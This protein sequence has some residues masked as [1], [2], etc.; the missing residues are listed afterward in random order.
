MAQNA[1][2]FYSNPEAMLRAMGVGAPEGLP[3]PEFGNPQDI[4]KQRD[5][6][7]ASIFKK[8]RLLYKILERHEATIQ[9][10]W[11]K[12]TKEQKRK[13]VLAAW[14]GAMPTAHRPDFEAFKKMKDVGGRSGT[15]YRADF[16]WPYINQE[17]LTK[18]K[19]LLLFMNARGRHPPSDFAAA[20]YEAMHIGVVTQSIMPVFLNEHV[21]LFNGKKAEADYA[22]LLSWDDHPDAFQWLHTRKHMQ[23]GEGLLILEAQEK[24]M[25]FLVKCAKSILHDVA[26]ESILDFSPQPAPPSISD[27][28]NGFA[29]LALI[30]A[31][32]AYRTPAHLSWD[33][34]VSLLNAKRAAAEDHLW[35]LRDDPSYFSYTMRDARE[36]RQEILADTR[37]QAHPVLRYGREDILWARIIGSEVTSAQIVFEAWAELHRQSVE[38]RAL[39]K[40]HS[41]KIKSEDDLPTEYL[42]AILRFRH[43]LNETTKGPIE[44]LKVSF[45]SSPPWRGYFVRQP[46]DDLKQAWIKI[47]SKPEVST[48]YPENFILYFFRILWSDPQSVHL[49]KMTNVV[50]ELQHTI[51]SDPKAKDLVSSTCAAHIGDLSILGE[52]IR[53]IELYQPW[54]NMFEDQMVDMQSDIDADYQKRTLPWARLLNAT[55]G[56]EDVLAR[57]GTPTPERF[58]YPVEKRRTKETTE[59]MRFAEQNLDAFW[60]KVDELVHRNAGDLRGTATRQLMLQPRLL[61]RT[62][63]WT[64]PKTNQN[65]KSTST[66]AGSS[67]QQ[68]DALCKPLSEIYFDLEYRTEAKGKNDS[69]KDTQPRS[70]P[71]TRGTPAPNAIPIDGKNNNDLREDNPL[72]PQPIFAVDNRALKV[73]KTVFYTPSSGSTPGEVP[74]ADFVHA[75]VATGFK[76]EK[77]YGSVWQFSPTK[78]DIERSIQFHEPH[79]SG[80]IPYWIARR[81]GRRLN[82]AYGWFGG[83]FKLAEK[84]D[85]A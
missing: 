35:S 33:R 53:Q 21:M 16:M 5:A 59:M 78:L 38:L 18:P 45:P 71:K 20:D 10:R 48:K 58:R 84:K 81:H 8:F 6:R 17:D 79:P 30:K 77:L 40:K 80:K 56:S 31:E 32:A 68:I 67:S 2:D 76:S 4:R 12:K 7:V 69:D 82:R 23:P 13:I 1:S 29:S 39:K 83:M 75:M 57:Y 51:D 36:H 72:D 63:Q 26:E 62:P 28:E 74:W 22:Q 43:F 54:A 24:T 52:C 55:K 70:K 14:G 37:G 19:T 9:K 47:Q 3:M 34:I 85:S 42:S 66:K 64:E 60:H 41:S 15:Q 44:Q 73:F 25:D 50:D 27:Q 46:E 65:E 49:L 11:M 61:H